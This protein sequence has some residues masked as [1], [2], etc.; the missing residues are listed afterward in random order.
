[1]ATSCVVSRYRSHRL[2]N[3]RR[4]NVSIQSAHFA[5]RSLPTNSAS[6]C[7]PSSI[8]CA[9]TTESSR[10]GPCRGESLSRPSAPTPRLNSASDKTARI[11]ATP[12]FGRR[13]P[14]GGTCRSLGPLR[15]RAR[16]Q[17]SNERF[18]SFPLEGSFGWLHEAL[19][20]ETSLRSLSP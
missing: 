8:K 14:Y 16:E 13:I 1:M 17:R 7:W 10:T 18:L 12:R 5:T 11:V 6:A 2:L 9:G 19:V 3:R 20:F 4:A 15:S